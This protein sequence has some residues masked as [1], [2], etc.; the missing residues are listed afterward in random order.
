MK[1]KPYHHHWL[2]SKK[3]AWLILSLVFCL[4]SLLLYAYFWFFSPT[5]LQIVYQNWDGPVYAVIAQSL[6]NPQVIAHNPYSIFKLPEDF[7]SSFPLYPL[8]IRLFSFVGYFTATILVS[9]L[10]S[11]AAIIAF[12]ELLR[13]NRLTKK[14]LMLALIF[15]FLPPRWFISSHI[16]SSEPLFIFLILMSLIYF[17]RR[18]Y[19][20]SGIFLALAQLARSQAILFFIAYGL[21]ALRDAFNH[22][23]LPLK[24]WPYLLS[25]LGLLGFFAYLKYQYGNFFAFFEALNK[26][27]VKASF[28]FQVFTAYPHPLLPTFSL[29][30]HFWIYLVN[31]LA[32]IWLFKRHQPFLALLAAI[33]TLAMSFIIHIDLA[34]YNL[35]LI[36]FILIAFESIIT[37]KSFLAAVLILLPALYGFTVKFMFF[38]R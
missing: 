5:K 37:T 9:L 29:E 26:W 32:T 7:A 24:F 15:I 21:M 23:R 38:N 27:P 35:P 3:Q 20:P 30:N 11:L 17:F 22:R 8:I 2:I 13:I 18:R 25:P 19:L 36:P 16:G 4:S 10:F 14:P 28:P 34:R 33:Y 6:Y 1:L 31:I 12:Y